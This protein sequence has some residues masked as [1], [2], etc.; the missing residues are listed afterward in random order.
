MTA[1]IALAGYAGCGKDE[2]ARA[3]YPLGFQRACFGDIIKAQLDPLIQEHFGFSAFTED[4][5]QKA[6]IRPVLEQWG[7]VNYDGVS[8]QFHE[9]LPDLAVNTRIV[10]VREARRWRDMGG[11]IWYVDRPGVQAATE[12]E[13]ERLTELSALGFDAILLNNGSIAGLHEMVRL[14][15][16]RLKPFRRP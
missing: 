1:R 9:N 5:T 12:W 8:R 3:L 15:A 13:H 10:R 7:E 2:A 16:L 11:V 4:R 14:K 6:Q